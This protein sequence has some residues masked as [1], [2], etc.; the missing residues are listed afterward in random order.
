MKKYLIIAAAAALT[1]A[2]C[3]KIENYSEKNN[4]LNR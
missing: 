4:E 3:A 1:L 2:A